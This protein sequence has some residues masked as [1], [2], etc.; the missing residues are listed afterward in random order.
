MYKKKVSNLLKTKYL[1][2]GGYPLT[3]SESAP[4]IAIQRV[5]RENPESTC[6]VRCRCTSAAELFAKGDAD[7]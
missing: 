6:T 5:R 1:R 4:A 7:K 2:I 3:H